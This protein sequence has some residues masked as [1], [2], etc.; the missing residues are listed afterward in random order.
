[1]EIFVDRVA[2]LATMHTKEKAIEPIL[3]KE[4]GITI[5][6]PQNFNTDQFGTFT[7]EIQRPASQLETAKIKAL[8]AMELMG[9]NLAVA[10]EGA[11]VP[12][13]L[14][15]YLSCDREV[16]FFYDAV[17]DLE[18]YGEELSIETNYSQQEV[19]TV[20]EALNFA[21]RI[22]FPSHGI[23][24]RTDKNSIDPAAIIKG[25]VSDSQL[26][27]AI[28]SISRQTSNGKVFLETDMRAMHNPTRMKAIAKATT[29]LVTK[30]KNCCLSGKRSKK[31]ITL[32]GV[33]FTD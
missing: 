25:I 16:V 33:W 9:T 4:L 21:N 27:A 12:H 17:H 8:K 15:P 7:R 29:N 32:C 2:V 23:I 10:S 5:V 1:M 19:T 31:R 18:V 3:S 24:A 13:P 30:L 22:G 28:K 11:F 26:I 6:V 14:L 20:E